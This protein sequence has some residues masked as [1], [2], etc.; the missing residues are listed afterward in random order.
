M[1]FFF[2]LLEPIFRFSTN[3]FKASFH[4]VFWDDFIFEK[5]V[6]FIVEISI[7]FSHVSKRFSSFFKLLFTV[8]KLWR[9]REDNS[10]YNQHYD[11]PTKINS[12]QW[13][14][15]FIKFLIVETPEDNGAKLNCPVN[16]HN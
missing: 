9:F 12:L 13:K 7:E 2:L 15:V 14:P 6:V 11:S 16:T 1:L 8:K 5:E 4:L 10:R 3:L